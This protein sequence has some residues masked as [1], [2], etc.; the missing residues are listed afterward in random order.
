MTIPA[1]ATSLRLIAFSAESV[2]GG[3][4]NE[5]VQGKVPSVNPSAEDTP[6]S[7]TWIVGGMALSAPPRTNPGSVRVGDFVWLD[8][9]ADGQQDCPLGA[10]GCSALERLEIGI[11][12]VTVEL[13]DGNGAP[14]LNAD[15]TARTQVTN[16]DGGYGFIGLPAGQYQ[17]RFNVS[18]AAL[19]TI[20]T[21]LPPTV[22]PDV[23]EGGVLTLSPTMADLGDD[24][25][26]SDGSADNSFTARSKVLDPAEP[27]LRHRGHRHRH[28]RRSSSRAR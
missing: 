1:N 23:V 3:E 17:V 27:V 2:D 20:L 14:V 19:A 26:D 5:T 12:N 8:V 21:N 22:L 10:T 28:P 24:N 9:D 15:G 18:D 4:G 11:P 16:A 7:F 13:L 6:A 25:I